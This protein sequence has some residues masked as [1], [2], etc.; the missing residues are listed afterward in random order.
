[1]QYFIALACLIGFV[2]MCIL[3]L[4]HV[5][6]AMWQQG[7]YSASDSPAC[8][9]PRERQLSRDVSSNSIEPEHSH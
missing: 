2:A 4:T 6:Y 5:L 7:P 9:S 3:G 8:A 1:M